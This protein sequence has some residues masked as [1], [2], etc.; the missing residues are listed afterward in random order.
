MENNNIQGFKVF[1]P[2]WTCRDFQ[3]DVGKTYT[4]EDSPVCCQQGFHFCLNAAD[5]FSYYSFDPSNKVAEVIALGDVDSKDDTSKCCT[6]KLQIVREIPWD[7]VLRIVNTGK[8][9]TG[10]RNTGNWN[11]GDQNT[12]N[13]NTGNQNTGS[14]NVGSCNT[15][16]Q[17]TGNWNAGDWNAGSWNTGSRN[18]GNQNTGDYN[19]GNW[20]VG[21][22]NTGDYNTG[23]WNVG[24]W[25]RSSFN[26]GCF[27]TEEQKISMFN[28]PTDWTYQDWLESNA[29]HLLNQ[30]PRYI[31]KWIHSDEM[32]DEEKA[33]H[34]SHET[35]GGYLK[36]LDESK[37][38]Q[39]WW[40]SLSACQK[41]IIKAIPNF[42]PEIF[43]QCTGIKTEE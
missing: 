7:E 28:K 43:E 5:C 22:W 15:G 24:D 37:C 42:D 6:N 12:G 38:G 13:R 11:T 8:N 18:T 17:N 30:I 20:N 33:N 19:T 39:L 40:D 1:G 32:T 34:P 16:N 31:V 27:M 26:T 4:M 3:Y 36:V 10:L 23:N 41:D 25:N 14:R 21:D 35:T 9:C 2:D 29:R